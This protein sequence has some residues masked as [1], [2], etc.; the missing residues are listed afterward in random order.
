MSKEEGKIYI[1]TEGLGKVYFKPPPPPKYTVMFTDMNLQMSFPNMTF[2]QR[3]FARWF[4]SA[5]ITV[6]KKEK[7]S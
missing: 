2:M 3:W 5:K 4:L 1:N 6:N 7:D